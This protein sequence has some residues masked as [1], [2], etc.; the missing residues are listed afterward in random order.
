MFVRNVVTLMERDVVTRALTLEKL[1]K[2]KW[3]RRDLNV[4]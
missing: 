2:E 3:Q 4:L 1:A